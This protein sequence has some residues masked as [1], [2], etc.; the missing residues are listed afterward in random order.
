MQL[1]E[2]TFPREHPVHPLG[3]AAAEVDRDR[4]LLSLLQRQFVWHLQGA[5]FVDGFAP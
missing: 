1:S 3:S 4:N 2:I 5:V